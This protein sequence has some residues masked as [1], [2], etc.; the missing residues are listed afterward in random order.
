[1]GTLRSIR[2]FCAVSVAALVVVPSPVAA[3]QPSPRAECRAACREF[4][5]A[6][7]SDP[8]D[9]YKLRLCRKAAT[10]ICISAVRQGEALQCTTRPTCTSDDECTD[11]CKWP[12]GRPGMCVD[13]GVGDYCRCFPCQ[14]DDDCVG[15]GF[16]DHP[17]YILLCNLQTGDCGSCG[18]G[19]STGQ[20]PG[21]VDC[22]NG[23]CCPLEYACDNTNLT[24]V[25]VDPCPGQ[26]TC[27]G[28]QCCP[29]G[30]L[31]DGSCSGVCI[32]G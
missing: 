21:Q 7:A 15:V 28:N 9:H 20:C 19:S 18:P 14:S 16:C 11:V 8:T 4:C 2:A 25:L 27:C 13:T 10:R 22:F 3:H 29:G 12:R 31:C 17:G 24:C 30:Y 23:L 1:M 32:P 6:V 5:R 26:V